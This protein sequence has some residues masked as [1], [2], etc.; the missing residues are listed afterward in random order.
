[1]L[2]QFVGESRPPAWLRPILE[3]WLL[4]DQPCSVENYLKA[5]P[6]ATWAAMATGDVGDR[7]SSR[8]RSHAAG[9]PPADDNDT[10]QAVLKAL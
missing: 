10:G 1:L 6:R 9:H 7:L 8:H 3:G 2:R 4:A 5:Q